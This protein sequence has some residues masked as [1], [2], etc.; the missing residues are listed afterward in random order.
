[1]QQGK[2]I[3]V[4]APS[5]SG[6]TT[7]VRQVLASG[8]N[9]EF[10]V[11]ACSRQ[12]RA[13]EKDGIDYYFLSAE[14]FKQKIAQNAFVEWEEVYA[15]NYYGTLKSE[16]ERIWQKGNHV[17]FDVDVVG[18]LNIKRQYP[19]ACLSLFVQPPSIKELEKRLRGRS[20]DSEE[21]IQKRIAKA[22]YELSFARQFD[23]IIINDILE[24][25]VNETF[26]A[27]SEFISCK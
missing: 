10:S 11:S 8:L 21:T 19:E 26:K 24:V 22:E 12:P 7:I 9:L 3:V 13:N 14:A 23:R 2:M 16:V 17:I 20:T 27:I 4:S 25:A 15:G 6:K 1:M 18:G 5:G